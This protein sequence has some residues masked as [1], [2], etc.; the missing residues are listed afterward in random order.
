MIEKEIHYHLKVESEKRELEN[1]DEFCSVA[2]FSILDPLNYGFLD[3][4]QIKNFYCKFKSSEDV[5]KEDI[6]AILRRMNDDCDARISFREF[7]LA[8]TPE[9]AG[10]TTEAARLQFNVDKKK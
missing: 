9:V 5:H 2:L 3:F 6:N 4:D 10:L 7:C 1:M 8:I